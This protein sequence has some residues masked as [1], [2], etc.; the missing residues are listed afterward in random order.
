MCYIPG[1]AANTKL[2]EVFLAAGGDVDQLEK[3]T[4]VPNRNSKLA[5]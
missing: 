3:F 2:L 1:T 5:Q 4:D